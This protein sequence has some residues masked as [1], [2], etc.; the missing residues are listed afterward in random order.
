MDQLICQKVVCQYNIFENFNP[1]N[2][3][4][5]W[6]G[7]SPCQQAFKL[8]DFP[9]EKYLNK[10]TKDILVDKRAPLMFYPENNQLTDLPNEFICMEKWESCSDL[11]DINKIAD[12]LLSLQGIPPNAD[13][14]VNYLNQRDLIEKQFDLNGSLCLQFGQFQKLY[15]FLIPI[16]TKQSRWVP[17]S[18]KSFK[19]K[20]FTRK[21]QCKHNMKAKIDNSINKPGYKKKINDC[22]REYEIIID[23]LHRLVFVRSFNIHSPQCT[24][25]TKKESFKA[26]QE[27]ILYIYRHFGKSQLMIESAM[28]Q[29]YKNCW[30]AIEQL[31][32]LNGE[33]L[34]NLICKSALENNNNGDVVDGENSSSK[35]KINSFYNDLAVLKREIKIGKRVSKINNDLVPIDRNLYVNVIPIVNEDSV[36]GLFL[37]HREILTE[38]ACATIW[39]IDFLINNG[40][41]YLAITFPGPGGSNNSYI[42]A[43]L[44]FSV[45]LNAEIYINMILYLQEILKSANENN[46]LK[47]GTI[48]GSDITKYANELQNCLPRNV[49]IVEKPSVTHDS[50][51]RNLDHRGFDI[52]LRALY[53][54]SELDCLFYLS[55]IVKLYAKDYY[56]LK[57]ILERHYSYKINHRKIRRPNPYIWQRKKLRVFQGKDSIIAEE[58]TLTDALDFLKDKIIYISRLVQYRKHWA[59]YST[60]ITENIDSNH[61]LEVAESESTVAEFEAEINGILADLRSGK[62]IEKP[63]EE[64]QLHGNVTQV[65]LDNFKWERYTSLKLKKAFKKYVAIDEI[66]LGAYYDCIVSI[67]NFQVQ[68]LANEIDQKSQSLYAYPIKKAYRSPP[69]L[70]NIDSRQRKAFMN[71]WKPVYNHL[72]GSTDIVRELSRGFPALNKVDILH[73]E[74]DDLI[75]DW[76]CK[77]CQ[78]C[79]LLCIPCKH[80]IASIAKGI[81]TEIPKGEQKIELVNFFDDDEITNAL[82]NLMGSYNKQTKEKKHHMEMLIRK[83]EKKITKLILAKE[84]IERVLLP[85]LTCLDVQ[86]DADFIKRL[87]EIAIEFEDHEQKLLYL[88]DNEYSSDISLLSE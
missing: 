69:F 68:Q 40:I 54:K 11:Q 84:N 17:L 51:C 13:Q 32:N 44:A 50:F 79:L 33:L 72:G 30:P 24:Q 77:N 61:M 80:I 52:S 62:T 57:E 41:K 88:S 29:M 45:D 15:S 70:K 28:R 22:P 67:F 38:F 7:K 39:N 6:I 76:T 4:C 65:S 87:N 85:K 86:K 63:T 20:I 71:E 37:S 73:W 14:I 53:A 55:Q 83:H 82:F 2:E 25:L 27:I 46:I 16:K 18:P 1:N 59:L 10:L 31:G 21:F 9:Y 3:P 8:V 81:M 66:T 43:T 36:E 64:L 47:V 58:M 75:I 42:A 74:N 48:F 35:I 12:S 19:N 26:F 34:N 60:V 5:L 78:Q 23:V 56:T 49:A